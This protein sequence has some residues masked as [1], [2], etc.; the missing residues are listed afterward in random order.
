MSKNN[1]RRGEM[2][3]KKGDKV[4]LVNELDPDTYK[5]N[6]VGDIYTIEEIDTEYSFRT[7]QNGEHWYIAF[8]DVKPYEENKAWQEDPPVFIDPYKIDIPLAE[9]EGSSTWLHKQNMKKYDLKI[10]QWP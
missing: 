5:G 1:E 10:K 9:Q 4:V 8:N 7:I 6:Q 2:K 3:Y